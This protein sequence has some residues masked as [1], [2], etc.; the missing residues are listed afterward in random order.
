M[1][2]ENIGQFNICQSEVYVVSY[3]EKLINKKG[4]E[5]G[6]D[7][8]VA[9]SIM[10]LENITENQLKQNIRVHLAIPTGIKMY[11]PLG[12]FSLVTPRS[13]IAYK[14]GD[15]FSIDNSPGLIDPTYRGEVKVI[16]TI[17]I[18]DETINALKL[19]VIQKDEF[20]FDVVLNKYTRIAQLVPVPNSI[21]INY[22]INEDLYNNFADILSSSRGENGLGSSGI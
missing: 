1:C 15:Y 2:K 6:I 17:Y 16:T 3:D 12:G 9:E 22:I 10:L 20:L 14:A 13:G 4:N 11:Q 5:A 7:L 21:N 18:N 19:D 8:S